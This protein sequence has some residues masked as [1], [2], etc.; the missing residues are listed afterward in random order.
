MAAEG[1]RQMGDENN[2]RRF[3]QREQ[4][5]AAIAALP[6]GCREVFVLRELEELS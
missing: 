6:V 5:N 1:I 3:E 2:G 4:I